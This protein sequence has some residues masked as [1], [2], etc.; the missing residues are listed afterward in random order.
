MQEQ[1]KAGKKSGIIRQTFAFDGLVQEDIVLSDIYLA[2]R[3][4]TFT[5]DKYYRDSE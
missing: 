2:V 5:R 3:L 4:D 1:S